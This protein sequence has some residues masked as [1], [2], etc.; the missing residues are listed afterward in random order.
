MKGIKNFY[1]ILILLLVMSCGENIG[2][3]EQDNISSNNEISSENSDSSV[4]NNSEPINNNLE[5]ANIEEVI[6]EYPG[7]VLSF[8]SD[9]EKECIA[10]V[11]TTDSLKQMEYDVMNEGMIIQEHYDYFTSCNIPTPPGIGIKE[12]I[13]AE[14]ASETPRETSYSTSFASV[15]NLESIETSG[16]SPYLEKV[17]ESTL[18]LFYNSIEVM[19]LA[20]SLCDYEFN[21]EIQGVLNFISDLTIV[22]TVDGVRRGYFVEGNPQT[23]EKDIY[24]AVFSEDGLTYTDKKALG[25]PVSVDEVAW[26]VPDAVLMSNGLIRVYWVYTEDKT[27][28]E[29]IVSATSKTTKGVD[30]TMDPGYRFDSGYVDFEVMKAEDGDWR[31]VMSYTPHYLPDI[32]QSLFYATSKDGLDWEF[33]EERITPESYSY[34]DPTTIPINDKTYLLITSGS[35]NQMGDKPHTLYSAELKLP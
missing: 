6:D 2:E 3:T 33:I 25:F 31:A 7:G 17:D 34:L 27:S 14:I 21:C 9:E 13:S 16:V 4:S 29:T 12:G 5:K 19:G 23:K 35:P 24:T 11:S 10:Q 32:P 26:G 1:L 22:E 30:F 20:V 15:E 8:L 28:D 18:R